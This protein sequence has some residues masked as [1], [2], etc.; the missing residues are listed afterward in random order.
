MS[1]PLSIGLTGGI[2]SGKSLVADFFRQLGIPVYTSDIEAKKLMQTDD[3]IRSSLI[4][5]FGESVYLKSGDLNR[6]KLAEVIFS[7]NEALKKVNAIVHPQVR[8]HF[9][10]W[11]LKQTEA[12]YV[13]QE[14]AIIFDTGLYKNFDKIITVTADES[15]RIDRVV[16]RDS[17]TKESV[18]ERMSKQMS[19]QERIVKS[20]FVIYN[21]SELVIPQIIAIHN[22]LLEL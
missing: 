12:P 4:E 1:K 7:N 20:D 13:I 2:G 22:Q 15:I 8:L 14:S 19:E 10:E 11:V 3:L 17:C 16:E 9:Q 5:A 18:L 6:V 21:N